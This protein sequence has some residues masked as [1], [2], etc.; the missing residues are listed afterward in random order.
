MFIKSVLICIVFNLWIRFLQTTSPNDSQ[1]DMRLRWLTNNFGGTEYYIKGRCVCLCVCTHMHATLTQSCLDKG[2][3]DI[4][5]WKGLKSSQGI[6]H[7]TTLPA[8]I[9][10]SFHSAIQHSSSA[11]VKPLWLTRQWVRCIHK[12]ERHSCPQGVQLHFWL[13]MDIILMVY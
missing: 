7:H 9:T 11:H 10:M 2:G 13:V 6:L 1:F 3:P 5:I 12:N 8:W 4:R